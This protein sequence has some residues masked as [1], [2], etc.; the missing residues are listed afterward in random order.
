M[1][2]AAHAGRVVVDRWR[3]REAAVT[4]VPQGA[5][6]SEDGHYWWDGQQWQL[7]RQAGDPR[8]AARVAAGLP[9]ALT[10]ITDAQR[11]GYLGQPSVVVEQLNAGQAVVL[12]MRDEPGGEATA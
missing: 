7:V 9:A 6:V 2:N 4:N 8:V 5:T 10:D 3:R 11:Q 12:A 1:R